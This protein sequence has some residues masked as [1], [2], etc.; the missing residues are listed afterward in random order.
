MNL[1]AK[2]FGLLLLVS[3]S[4]IL[5]QDS[6]AFSTRGS[7]WFGGGASF[8]SV[9]EDSYRVRILSV[10]PIFRFFPADHFMVGPS[11]S[12]TGMYYDMGGYYNETYS[13]NQFNFGLEMGGVFNVA[14]SVYPYVMSGA[15]VVLT[16]D[17][18]SA[19]TG[20]VVPIT[21]GIIIS[22]GNFWGLQIEPT[23]Q[24]LWSEGGEY[25][26]SIGIKIGVC[27]LGGKSAISVLQGISSMVLR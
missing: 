23:F 4:N 9:G 22:L 24:N 15:N 7:K 12:W 6:N 21:G 3:S 13:V 11:F 25:A 26:N 10:A 1:R 2:V 19:S 27:A 5:A 16:G 20:F 8:T 18:G 14:G 17:E